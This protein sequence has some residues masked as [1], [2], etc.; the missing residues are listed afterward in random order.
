MKVWFVRT[1]GIKLVS[2]GVDVRLV[3]VSVWMHYGGRRGWVRILP[4]SHEVQTIAGCAPYSV[5]LINDVNQQG[6]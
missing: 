4:A 3:L 2:V 1:G 5:D 6:L